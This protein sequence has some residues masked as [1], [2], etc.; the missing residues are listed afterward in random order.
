MQSFTRLELALDWAS[1]QGRPVV[2]LARDPQDLQSA[3]QVC[4]LYEHDSL[5]RVSRNS[6]PA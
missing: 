4:W 1:Q 3:Q 6:A 5:T 2:F